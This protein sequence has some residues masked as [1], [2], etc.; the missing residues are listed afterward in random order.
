L[1]EILRLARRPHVEVARRATGATRVDAHAGITVRHP[2]LRIDQ[3][4]VLI[5]V[6]R[7]FQ[8]LGRRLDEAL[9]IALVAFLER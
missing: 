8:H 5:L 3:L 7:A 6:A 9:P 1:I 2:F 4:P